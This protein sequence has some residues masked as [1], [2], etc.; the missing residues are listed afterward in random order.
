MPTAPALTPLTPR[1]LG[2]FWP[3]N[4]TVN[5]LAYV[6]RNPSLCPTARRGGSFPAAT[7]S[8]VCG[9]R[10][11]ITARYVVPA[12]GSGFLSALTTLGF[13][14]HRGMEQ[15]GWNGS[16]ASSIARDP[17][18]PSLLP[19]RSPYR[20][21]NLQCDGT[22]GITDW[23]LVTGRVFLAQTRL[24]GAADTFPLFTDLTS[25]NSNRM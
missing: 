10:E 3:R 2:V 18:S 1:S 19:S 25:K 21:L 14:G 5:W 7:G 8:K 16:L 17:H 22:Q 12:S 23:R 24:V 13:Q 9:Q 11:H 6:K 20:F 4:T 15:R